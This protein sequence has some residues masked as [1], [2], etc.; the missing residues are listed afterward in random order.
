MFQVIGTS[1][2]LILNGFLRLSQIATPATP[3]SGSNSLYF[4]SDNNLYMKN[5]AGT[6]TQVS[7]GGSGANQALSNL[8]NPTAINQHLLF[9]TDGAF[10]IGG[11]Y[12]T[13]AGRPAHIWASTAVIGGS[14][15][16]TFL[17][18]Q[19]VQVGI[20][21]GAFRAITSAGTQLTF[22]R[23]S[24]AAVTIEYETITDLG[25][26]AVQGATAGFLTAQYQVPVNTQ[27][28]NTVALGC[29]QDLSSGFSIF[30][31]GN[32]GIATSGVEAMRVDENQNIFLG[33]AAL[34][35][36]ATDGFTSLASVPGTPTSTPT[37]KTGLIPM[38]ID[39]G[40]GKFWA[41]Y[42]GAWN[43][44]DFGG[45]GGGG[46]NQSLSN[47]TNP[48]AINQPLLIPNVSD[49]PALQIGPIPG[50]ANLQASISTDSTF[51][52]PTVLLIQGLG[53]NSNNYNGIYIGN[54]AS[55]VGLNIFLNGSGRSS[56]GGNNNATIRMENG[57]SLRIKAVNGLTLEGAVSF[58]DQIND[59]SN[60]P[61]ID[62]DGRT[63]FDSGDN[64][65]V[66][67]ENR[68][69]SDSAGDIII[70]WE[71]RAI[72]SA[73]GNVVWN[74]DLGR[75][76]DTG[77]SRSL[78][79]NT[80]TAQDSGETVSIDWT[81]RTLHN[82]AGDTSLDWDGKDLINDDNVQVASWAIGFTPNLLA[83]D[84]NVI[85]SGANF[86]IADNISFVIL[87]YTV[88]SQTITLPATPV[89]GQIIALVTDGGV[90]A[91]TIAPNGGQSILGTPI[92]SITPSAPIKFIWDQ[93]IGAWFPF[94]SS[95]GGGGGSGTVT[96]VALTVPAFLS[97]SGSPITTS[98]TLALSFSGTAIPVANG[99]TGDTT[100]TAHGV[101]IGAGTSAVAVASPGTAGQ[102]LTSNG[103]SSDPT[104]QTIAGS[105][106]LL[107][108][109]TIQKFTSTGT[110]TGYRFVTPGANATAGATYTNNGQTFTVLATIS[111]ASPLYT[112]STGAPTASGTLTKAS[113][114]GDTTITFSSN[115]A[116]ATYT[117]PTGPAPLYIKVKL[118]GSGGGGAGSGT[119][120][121]GSGGTGGDSYFDVAGNIA[122]GAVGGNGTSGD[123]GGGGNNTLGTGF[124][125]IINAP[126]TSGA[127]SI[128]TTS[129][130]VSPPGGLG[131]C[132][133]LGGGGRG[134]A[135]GTVGSTLT[136]STARANSGSGGGGGGAVGNAGGQLAG[137]GGGSGGTL[138]LLV[139]TVAS[140][141]VYAIGVHGNGGAAGTNGNNGGGGADGYLVIEEYYQ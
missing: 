64:F 85:S 36:G 98:G 126:G 1:E 14:S 135:N 45:G 94:E 112:S 100:L 117:P 58:P 18:D 124:T 40:N 136:G 27:S 42:G 83:L 138:E 96:S 107:K 105:S 115:V 111:G 90:G 22:F 110:T 66:D 34:N 128:Y 78:N 95:G 46:A 8:T 26:I 120:S 25:T 113:G 102:V 51:D 123:G 109:P 131:G 24:V 70:D 15:G 33:I 57:G 16:T 137:A 91:L 93:G 116:L 77:G 37:L 103:A 106:T 68:Q 129:T 20:F 2:N 54:D 141:Y 62:P 41:Y 99:G 119:A 76:L 60:S 39:T 133:T 61:S 32:V 63:L 101:L 53:A 74:I 10:D 140:S 67:W 4:K 69:L 84:R 21:S 108:I 87:N 121:N 29:S 7:G 59:N 97:V 134:G 50:D 88:G 49:G 130:A 56:D 104:M 19:S 52:G 48:T 82:N 5:S 23:A 122:G 55:E 81:G 31:A 127:S 30:S 75:F 9:G 28:H 44:I 132:S 11:P 80:R 86:T 79:I 114:T 65:S 3:P 35:A 71:S 89:Q 13:A 92:T 72:S 139:T 38:T 47:L 17:A 12:P 73:S 6:E 43:S 118:V 125:A